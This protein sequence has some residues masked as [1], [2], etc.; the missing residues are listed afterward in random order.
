MALY[1]LRV[2]LVGSVLLLFPPLTFAQQYTVTDLGRLGGE[3]SGATAINASGQVV[4]WVAASGGQHPFLWTHET[5]MQ[6]LGTLP[7]T[8]SCSANAINDAGHIVGYCSGASVHAFL[9]TADTGMTD[10]SLTSWS[11][12]SGIN[13]QNE[14]IINTRDQG[15][16]V[17]RD[18][19]ARSLGLG[20]ANSIND[21][22]QV[23]GQDVGWEAHAILWDEQ[24]RHDLGTLEGSGRSAAIAI[25]ADG[26]PVGSCQDESLPIRTHAIL[27]NS[28]GIANLGGLN[29]AAFSA[30]L[31]INGDLIVGSSYPAAD[32]QS[33]AFLYDDNGPGYPVDLNDFIPIDSGWVLQTC[34][35]PQLR[36]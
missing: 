1:G 20:S 12:A 2:M 35:S 8:E 29:G 31:G 30:A 34:G 3:D 25:S 15:P 17:Y 14:I 13:N 21:R 26:V 22:G 6:D 28:T 10:I 32:G 33:H 9:W 16:S 7:D 11:I 19:S 5:G 24:G 4:G 27:W 18:G 23:V 36:P